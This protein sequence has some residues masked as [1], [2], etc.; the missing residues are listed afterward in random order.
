MKVNLGT[1]E[2]TDVQ[3]RAIRHRYGKTG[4]ATRE[5]VRSMYTDL[6]QE[7]LQDLVSELLEDHP[8]WEDRQ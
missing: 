2:V 3:R 6:A 7:D 1:I 4:L 5:E 8:Y